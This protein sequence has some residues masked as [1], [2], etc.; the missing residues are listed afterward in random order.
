MCPRG[1][2]DCDECT[3]LVGMMMMGTLYMIAVEGMR[4]SSALPLN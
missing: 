3:T 2:I 4:E 1:S